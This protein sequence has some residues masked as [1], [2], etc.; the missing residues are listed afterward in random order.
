[1]LVDNGAMIAWLGLRQLA[2]G[3]ALSVEASGVLPH[4]RTDQ[5]EVTWR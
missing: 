3:D 4:Q 5:V 1:V 2:S